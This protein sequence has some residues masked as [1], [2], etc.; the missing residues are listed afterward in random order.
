MRGCPVYLE[1]Q[2]ETTNRRGGIIR[3][4]TTAEHTM[5]RSLAIALAAL[6]SGLYLLPCR[7]ETGP[8]PPDPTA[9]APAPLTLGGRIEEA[10]RRRALRAADEARTGAARARVTQA[11][12]A[13][14]PRVDAQGS[15][16][17]GPVGA[18]PLGLGGVVG[19]P[20]KSHYGASLNLVQTLLDFGRAQ[21][22]L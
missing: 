16:T 12:S 9:P 11:R 4:R 6:L 10:P 3:G 2:Q 19:T 5:E 1:T 21:N 22:T 14:L 7:A 18:P 17:D 13:L 15:I 8:A 20:N